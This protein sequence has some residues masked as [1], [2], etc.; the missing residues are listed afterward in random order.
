MRLRLPA[1]HIPSN[2]DRKNRPLKHIT[3]YTSPGCQPCKATKRWLDKR[4]VEYQTVD[5]SQSP[6]DLEA[7]KELGY[8]AAPV[9]IVSNGDAETDI[10]WQGLHVDNLTKYTLEKAAA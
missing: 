3:V 10:H 5:V 6:A 9:V 1:P 4:G 7:L 2:T 8:N